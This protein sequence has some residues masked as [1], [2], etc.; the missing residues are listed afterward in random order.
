MFLYLE[1][2]LKKTDVL[3][4]DPSST[5]HFWRE[6]AVFQLA[7]A[8][9]ALRVHDVFSGCME[10]VM[11]SRAPSYILCSVEITVW[12]GKGAIIKMNLL[13]KEQ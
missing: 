6:K 5:E 9:C 10:T 4:P 11:E 12:T 1:N 8:D 7:F 3:N 2:A 13:N